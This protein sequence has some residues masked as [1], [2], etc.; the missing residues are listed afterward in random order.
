MALFGPFPTVREQVKTDSR[1]AAAIEFVAEALRQGSDSHR[2]LMELAEGTS[3]KIELSGGSFAINQS[4]QAKLRPEGFFEAHRKYIDVQVI[5]DGFESMEVE[6]LSRLEVSQEYNAE[7][8]FLKLADTSAASVLAMRAGD[9]AI[10]FPEDAHMPSL[11][12]DNRPSLVR[13]TVVKVPVA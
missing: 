12:L 13:K 2:R 4:Y 8:D 11:R 3:E 1:F 5:V 10:F 7:R 6:D 9:V